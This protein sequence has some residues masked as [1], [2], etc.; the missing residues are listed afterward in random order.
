LIRHENVNNIYTN[1]AAIS[2]FFAK[3]NNKLNK[4]EVDEI[5]NAHN[6]ITQKIEKILD[7]IHNVD[8]FI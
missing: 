4:E 7:E 5:L 1:L 6:I 3:Y 2:L 8:Y